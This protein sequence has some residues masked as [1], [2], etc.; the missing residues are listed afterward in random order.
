M[1]GTEGV[2]IKD[3]GGTGRRRGTENWLGCKTNILM[4]KLLYLI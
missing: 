1:N 4:K 2:D 3:V